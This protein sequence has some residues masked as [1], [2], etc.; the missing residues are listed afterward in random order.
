MRLAQISLTNY[1]VSGLQVSAN[2]KFDPQ[3]PAAIE[4]QDFKIDTHAEATSDN[5]RIWTI[6]LTVALIG[7]PEKT[8]PSELKLDMVGSV[9]VDPA[10]KEEN[11]ERLV[12]INGTSLVF[13]AARETIRAITS[14][15]GPSR[16]VLLPTVTFWEPK[17]E[18]LPTPVEA[19]KSEAPER[20]AAAQ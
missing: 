9:I 5:R 15:T 10:V 7:R 16:V 14:L 17:P 4:L 2:S 11:I 18:V 20:A 8:L 13:G 12:R 3:N 1:F 6:T 19:E